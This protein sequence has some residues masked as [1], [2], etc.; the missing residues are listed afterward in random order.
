MSKMEMYSAEW[1]KT[2]REERPRFQWDI[3]TV[4]EE[5]CICLCC[6]E[7]TGRWY[8]TDCQ[9]IHPDEFFTSEQDAIKR[10][11][12]L[13]KTVEELTLCFKGNK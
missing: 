10:C 13:N 6:Y 9:D 5:G 8:V 3:E 4:L 1:F 11:E 2:P 12:E 7:T